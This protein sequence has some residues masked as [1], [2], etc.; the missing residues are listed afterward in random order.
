MELV[1]KFQEKGFNV[2]SVYQESED[3]L[4]KLYIEKP[5]EPYLTVDLVE[6][7][8][9]IGYHV[10]VFDIR[11]PNSMCIHYKDVPGPDEFAF[12]A[13]DRKIFSTSKFPDKKLVYGRL[14]QHKVEFDKDEIKIKIK[15]KDVR[16]NPFKRNL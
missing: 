5:K 7:V 4:W 6:I 11:C 2:I 3:N 13:V 15:R 14:R 9:E 16:K 10:T 8:K 12:Y 1:E